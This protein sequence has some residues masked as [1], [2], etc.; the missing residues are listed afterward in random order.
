MT[1]QQE[2]KNAII[3]SDFEKIAL[4]INDKKIDVTEG[5]NSAIQIVDFYGHTELVKTIWNRKKV[6][7]TLQ[8][9]DKELYNKLNT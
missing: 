4:L 2:F 5:N 1:K 9:D 7:N 6:K 3:D 8:K